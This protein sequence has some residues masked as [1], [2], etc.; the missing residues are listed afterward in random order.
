MDPVF[1]FPRWTHP[2]LR[3]HKSAF[4]SCR[5]ARPRVGL[6]EG[7]P[8][9]CGGWKVGEG[10][11]EWDGVGDGAARGG[12]G[13]TVRVH[14]RC[15]LVN[16]GLRVCTCRRVNSP[17]F[18]HYPYFRGFDETRVPPRPLRVFCTWSAWLGSFG[19]WSA[20]APCYLSDSGDNNVARFLHA[21][22]AC[23]GPTLFL[24]VA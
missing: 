5:E 3:Y 24:P 4:I 7:P 8:V 13:E 17:R 6:A 1:V 16:R 22:I 9:R 12:G 18:T 15:S 14:A 19:A 2:Q 10:D 21:I 20:P 11:G 23:R